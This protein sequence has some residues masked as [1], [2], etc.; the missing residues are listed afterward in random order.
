MACGCKGDITKYA[1]KVTYANGTSRTF[2]TESAAK[3][4]V[5]MHEGSSYTKVGT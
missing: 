1:Y 5:S 3:M 4:S 2:Q